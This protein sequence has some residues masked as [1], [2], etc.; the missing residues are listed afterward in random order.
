MHKPHSHSYTAAYSAEPSNT[1]SSLSVRPDRDA[2]NSSSVYE[3]D[4]GGIKIQQ[5]HTLV[6][7]ADDDVVVMRSS[8]WRSRPS[9]VDGSFSIIAVTRSNTPKE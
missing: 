9:T 5:V 6:I 8:S 3:V 1:S 2:H 4:R 7:N